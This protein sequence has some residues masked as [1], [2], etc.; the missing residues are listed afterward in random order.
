[1]KA[2]LRY[3]AP[4]AP[5]HPN[6]FMLNRRELIHAG[7]TMAAASLVTTIERAEAQARPDSAPFQLSKRNIVNVNDI[8]FILN[9]YGFIDHIRQGSGI[10]SPFGGSAFSI[11]APWNTLLDADG[12]PNRIAASAGSFGGRFQVPDPRNFGG[13]YILDWD[14]NGTVNLNIVGEVGTIEATPGAHCRIS[15]A[16]GHGVALIS[17]GGASKASVSITLSGTTT[18]PQGIFVQVSSTG[19][20]GFFI[21]NVRFYR[22]EDAA[23]LAKDL[24]F[25]R[26]WKQPLVD[27]CPSAIRFMNWLGG[28]GDRNCR[29]ENRTPVNNAGWA[30]Q[31]QWNASP[32]YGEVSGTNQYKVS[33][34]APTPV[35]PK[36]TPASMLHGDLSTMR[37]ANGFTRCNSHLAV[38]SIS[39]APNG[40]VTTSSAHGYKSGDVI[41]HYFSLVQNITGT[42]NGTTTVTDVSITS[43]II[44]GMF[45]YGAGVQAGATIIS[46]VGKTLTLSR[47]A[48]ISGTGGLGFRAMKNLH[49]FPCTITVTGA[50]TYQLNV[51]TTD[52]GP[53]TANGTVYSYQF[54]SLQVGSG[55]DRTAYPCLFTDGG[56]PASWFGG[57]LRSSDYKTWYFDKTVSG[58]T[59]GSGNYLPG[60]WMFGATPNQPGV[61]HSGDVPIEVCVALVNELNA[62]SPAH[63]IGMWMNIPT[64]GLSSMDPDYTTASDWA[65]NAVDVVMNPSSKVRASGFSALGYFGATQLSQPVLII[66]YS[67]ELWPSGTNDGRGYLLNRGIQRWPSTNPPLLWNWQ[68]FPARCA[69]HAWCGISRRR[70]LR[71]CHASGLSWECGVHP[72]S[73][74]GTSLAIMKRYS[75]G[76]SELRQPQSEIGTPTTN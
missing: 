31:T 11:G 1:M 60:A 72:A 51:D 34:A 32:A 35:I 4:N 45:V 62:M 66:E 19:A 61:A 59:D 55:N 76:L 73:D 39:N 67:N 12:W 47:P 37:Y 33:A 65:V 56:T 5:A 2:T 23:D 53:F 40:L 42:F 8:S 17:T 64:W 57:Y 52:F 3:A 75:G 70:I 44:P 14:G 49:L 13:P 16:S 6:G 22:A 69:R 48:T 38:T 15:A 21:R 7:C 27:L 26:G 46:V 28:N 41:G 68:D 29:F 36:T 18:G 20:G 43:Q 25:R 50:M 58:Q 74:R 63:T 54:I 71:D 30:A 9:D 10:M 24:I